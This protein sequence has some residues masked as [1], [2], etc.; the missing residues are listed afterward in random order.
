[1][2]RRGAPRESLHLLLDDS[3]ISSATATAIRRETLALIGDAPEHALVSVTR[4]GTCVS[5]A[6]PRSPREAV[7]TEVAAPRSGG[8]HACVRDALLSALEAELK[9]GAAKTRVVVLSHGDD[10]SSKASPADVLAKMRHA[11]ATLA[12]FDCMLLTTVPHPRFE[13]A[14]DWGIGALRYVG[15]SDGEVRTAFD[16]VLRWRARSAAE[17]LR[18]RRRD[19]AVRCT[20]SPSVEEGTLRQ[21]RGASR[22]SRGR[23]RAPP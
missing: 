16:A 6:V 23:T 4:F 12:D 8:L 22:R 15:T 20:A 2:A 7:A 10:L 13:D 5:Q 9:R 18:A 1:M 21:R 11:R 14:S 19:G 3:G 17:L